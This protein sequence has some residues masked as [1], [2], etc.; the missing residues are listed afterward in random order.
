[1]VVAN[2]TPLSLHCQQQS[3]QEEMCAWDDAEMSGLIT[4]FLLGFL[5]Q[6]EVMAHGVIFA[7]VGNHTL[8]VLVESNIIMM[9]IHHECKCEAE[10]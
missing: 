4:A 3:E 1:M 2:N 6:H 5:R 7:H 9:I 10:F 8:D